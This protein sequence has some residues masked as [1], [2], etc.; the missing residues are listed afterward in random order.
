VTCIFAAAILVYLIVVFIIHSVGYL[1]NTQPLN[2]NDRSKYTIDVKAEDCAGRSSDKAL[3]TINVKP[4]C[5]PSW[6]GF[7]RIAVLLRLLLWVFLPS[8]CILRG[9]TRLFKGKAT[10]LSNV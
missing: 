9:L 7:E 5:R 3:V 10:A 8:C 2:Y 4:I 6:T 1:R